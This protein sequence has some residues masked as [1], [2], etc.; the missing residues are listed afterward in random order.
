ME[1][2]FVVGSQVIGINF[3]GDVC[4]GHTLGANYNHSIKRNTVYSSLSGVVILPID[5]IIAGPK[6]F[7]SPCIRISG[8]KIKSLKMNIK[9]IKY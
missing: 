1:D 4:V 8:Y 3:R 9:L 7:L 2:N 6:L 5:P